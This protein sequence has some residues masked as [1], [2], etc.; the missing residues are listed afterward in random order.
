MTGKTDT[1]TRYMAD[2]VEMQLLH[3]ITAD[4]ARTPTFTLFANPDYFV[5]AGA[6]NCTSPCVT[7]EPGFAWNHGDVSPDINTT[8]LGMVGPGIRHL[9]VDDTIWSD[10]AD[11]KQRLSDPTTQRN[12]LAGQ[13]SAMLEAATFRGRPLDETQAKALIDQGP[14]LPD[15]TCTGK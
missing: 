14:A 13:M 9:G 4:P 7:Q 1:L 10:H 12:T 2:P 3:M 11:I 8:W 5:Y 6:A 15:A